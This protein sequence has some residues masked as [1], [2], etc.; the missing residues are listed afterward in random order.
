MSFYDVHRLFAEYIALLLQMSGMLFAR[1]IELDGRRSIFNIDN[2]VTI[3]SI[4]TE[5]VFQVDENV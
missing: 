5:F 2:D 3:G 1:I 4:L